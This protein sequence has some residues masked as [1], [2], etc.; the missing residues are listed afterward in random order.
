[1]SSTCLNIAG[2]SMNEKK[3]EIKQNG[4]KTKSKLM[5]KKEKHK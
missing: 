2:Q 5:K 1:M 4:N 3:I